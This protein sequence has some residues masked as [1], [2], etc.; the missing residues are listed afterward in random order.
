MTESLLHIVDGLA[1][2]GSLNHWN[3]YGALFSIHI[4]HII[5]RYATFSHFVNLCQMLSSLVGYVW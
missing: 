1:K 4:F 2:L 5:A 3:T